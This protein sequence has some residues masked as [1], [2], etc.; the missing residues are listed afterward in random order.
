M[1]A[2]LLHNFTVETCGPSVDLSEV[3][4][5]TAQQSSNLAAF[6]SNSFQL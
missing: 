3:V 4:S 6:G 5:S 1:Q 2:K